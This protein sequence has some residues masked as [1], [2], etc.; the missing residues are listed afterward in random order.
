MADNLELWVLYESGWRRLHVWT[1]EDAARFDVQ[2]EAQR[3]YRQ[4][5]RG[6]YSVE[7][8]QPGERRPVNLHSRPGHMRA[9]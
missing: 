6:D 1:S 2:A 9:R 7:I 5:L 8:V 3:H 4:L